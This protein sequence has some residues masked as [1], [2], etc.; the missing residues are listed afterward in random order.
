MRDDRSPKGSTTSASQIIT[1]AQRASDANRKTS[2]TCKA[3]HC[4]C[5]ANGPTGSQGLLELGLRPSGHPSGAGFGD[6]P[7]SID[8]A[9]LGGVSKVEASHVSTKNQVFVDGGEISTSGERKL[10]EF[11]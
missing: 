9:A 4:G 6:S 3:Q 5:C 10:K 2:N 7:G 1:K 11:N 8:G